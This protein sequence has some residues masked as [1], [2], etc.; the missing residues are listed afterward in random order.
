MSGILRLVNRLRMRW[1][2]LDRSVVPAVLR[3]TRRAGKNN[4]VVALL[5]VCSA[6]SPGTIFAA[7][8]QQ[9]LTSSDLLVRGRK[10][11]EAGKLAEAE[12]VLDR[13]A[14]LAPSDPV[15][16]TLDGRVKGRLG[17][18]ASALALLK[19]VVQLTP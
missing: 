6:F 2:K 1:Y 19:R 8:P 12:L 3:A 13:A 11:L 4:R 9:A 17:E 18:Y 7:V 14:E 10:L 15:I 16:L 5:F